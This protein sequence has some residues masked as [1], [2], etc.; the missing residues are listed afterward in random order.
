MR[1]PRDGRQVTFA[2]QIDAVVESFRG[3]ERLANLTRLLL[4][5]YTYTHLIIYT[6]ILSL[7][8]ISFIAYSIDNF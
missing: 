4:E 5:F 3:L 2:R 6:T 7:L 1:G 8:L